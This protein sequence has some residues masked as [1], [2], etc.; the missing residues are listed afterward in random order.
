MSLSFQTCCFNLPN[1]VLAFTPSLAGVLSEC[2]LLHF[3]YGFWC[4]LSAA[5]PRYGADVLSFSIFFL[6]VRLPADQHHAQGSNKALGVPVHVETVC[7]SREKGRSRPTSLG[8][9]TEG[10]PLRTEATLSRSLDVP[11]PVTACDSEA[12]PPPCPV[13]LL[14]VKGCKI[15]AC[16]PCETDE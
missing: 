10:T 6:Q 2:L 11:S 8:P 3:A 13:L 9:L 7:N 14:G 1:A 12:R 5:R 15:P 16:L 4:C